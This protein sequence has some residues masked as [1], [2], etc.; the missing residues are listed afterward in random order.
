MTLTT[1][2]CHGTNNKFTHFD[3]HFHPGTDFHYR[4]C[5]WNGVGLGACSNDV[6]ITT[7]DIPSPMPAAANTSLPLFNS[8]TIKWSAV[9]N[10]SNSGNDPVL[11]YRV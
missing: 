11:S 3:G 6:I 7:N 9:V 2:S 5:G 4:V 10:G 1:K 8:I